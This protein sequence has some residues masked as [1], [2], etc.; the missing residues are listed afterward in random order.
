MTLLD[1]LESKLIG[2]HGL[3]NTNSSYQILSPG[4]KR[5]DKDGFRDVFLVE[6]LINNP[7]L[8]DY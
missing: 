2:K 4:D 1:L 8:A 5:S 7:V 6:D 3:L